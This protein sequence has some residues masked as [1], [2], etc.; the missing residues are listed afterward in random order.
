VLSAPFDAVGAGGDQGRQVRVRLHA[1]AA[2]G[3]A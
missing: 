2:A 3:S 1:N